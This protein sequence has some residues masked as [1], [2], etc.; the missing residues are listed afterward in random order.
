MFMLIFPEF[1]S[2]QFFLV[3]VHLTAL[4]FQGLLAANN[5]VAAGLS[6][7]CGGTLLALAYFIAEK[8]QG[9]F[10]DTRL[11][12]VF[13]GSFVAAVSSYILSARA[14]YLEKSEIID[15]FDLGIF[16]WML[17]YVLVYLY[18]AFCTLLGAFENTHDWVPWTLGSIGSC[19]IVIVWYCFFYRKWPKV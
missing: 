2:S 17:L 4:L 7:I 15:G 6:V 8:E 5:T 14:S 11:Q 19:S 9:K 1:I 18:V 10:K 13:I 16:K 3:L 12:A